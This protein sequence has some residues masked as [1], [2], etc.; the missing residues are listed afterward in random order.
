MKGF[1]YLGYKKGDFPISENLSKIIISLPMHPYLDKSDIE[2]IV[3]ATRTK[4]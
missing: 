1:E 3:G 2:F 4:E